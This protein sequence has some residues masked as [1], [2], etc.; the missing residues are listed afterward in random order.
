MGTQIINL[1]QTVDENNDSDAHFA[2]SVGHIVQN[3]ALPTVGHGDCGGMAE[4]Y[5]FYCSIEP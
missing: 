2:D 1:S 4:A 3:W 5:N